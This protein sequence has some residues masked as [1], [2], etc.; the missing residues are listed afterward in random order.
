MKEVKRMEIK[1]A[2]LE[3]W[4]PGKRKIKKKKE[5]WYS[6][7]FGEKQFLMPK[8]MKDSFVLKLYHGSR[9]SFYFDGN[10]FFTDDKYHMPAEADTIKRY[11]FIVLSDCV[12]LFKPENLILLAKEGELSLYLR[13]NNDEPIAYKLGKRYTVLDCP[14]ITVEFEKEKP[15]NDETY[16][17]PLYTRRLHLL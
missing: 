9:F 4:V 15:V 16:D 1:E 3:T 10:K 13:K 6:V 12:E 7:K 17:L 8:E 11:H 2:V 5:K 14:Y